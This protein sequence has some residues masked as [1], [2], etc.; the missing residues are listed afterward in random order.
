MAGGQGARLTPF[1]KVLPKPLL[2]IDEKPVIE[3]IIGKFK[4]FGGNNFNISVNYKS[5][6]LKS[7][8]KELKPNY[9]IKFLEEKKPM[10]TIGGLAHILKDLKKRTFFCV[11]VM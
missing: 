2:P 6:L 11:I 10:G 9:K 1:T 7:Y 4:S 8:F 3:H 5:L